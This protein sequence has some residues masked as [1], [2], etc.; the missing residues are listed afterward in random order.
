M[1]DSNVTLDMDQEAVLKAIAAA[2]DPVG[3]NDIVTISGLAKSKVTS[4]IK[5]LREKGLVDSPI[6]CKYCV[7]E[8]GKNKIK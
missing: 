2:G 5:Q 6:R 3:T 1:T 8:S 4:K 7:T